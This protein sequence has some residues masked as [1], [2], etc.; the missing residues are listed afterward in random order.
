MDS[1]RITRESIIWFALTWLR[2][3][4]ANHIML[5]LVTLEP[6]NVHQNARHVV[7]CVLI[8]QMVERGQSG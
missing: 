8:S 6:F 1:S 7:Q 5:S 2:L 3:L 4:S